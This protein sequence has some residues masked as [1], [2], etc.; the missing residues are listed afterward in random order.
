MG[1][2]LVDL[3]PFSPNLNPI[4]HVWRHLKNTVLETHPELLDMGASDEAIA[5][6]ESALREAWDTLPY[7]LCESLI[8][9]M[10]RRIAAML[11]AQGWHTKY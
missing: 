1:I 8:G 7:T 2:P 5:A 4:E 3:P 6:L 10:P 11:A 9:S